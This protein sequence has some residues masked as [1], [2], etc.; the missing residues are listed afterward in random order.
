MK[1]ILPLA[2]LTPTAALAHPW[3]HDGFTAATLMTH[4]AT[5]PDHAVMILAT[6]GFVAWRLWAR[7]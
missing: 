1:R 6:L 5:N 7:K 2:L 3:G 4:F